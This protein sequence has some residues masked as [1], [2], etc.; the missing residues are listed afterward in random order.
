MENVDVDVRKVTGADWIHGC[1]ILIS[2]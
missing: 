2:C 1:R